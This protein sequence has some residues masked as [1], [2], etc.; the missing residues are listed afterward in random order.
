M[1]EWITGGTSTSQLG[2]FR[3]IN[4]D[5]NV[6]HTNGQNIVV[7]DSNGDHSHVIDDVN[8]NGNTLDELDCTGSNVMLG[9]GT[10]GWRCSATNNDCSN[11]TT[12]ASRSTPSTRP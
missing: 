7:F 3:N 2:Y 5:D 8:V 10:H 9:G 12:T 1:A 6:I 4:I 11:S